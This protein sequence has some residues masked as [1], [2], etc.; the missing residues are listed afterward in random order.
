MQP[1][2]AAP[3]QPQP[4]AVPSAVPVAQPIQPQN[5]VAPPVATSPKGSRT[6]GKL[7][8]HEPI[9]KIATIVLTLGIIGTSIGLSF[10]IVTVR[11]AAYNKLP[12]IQAKNAQQ[13][14]GADVI[15]RP[16]DTLDLSQKVSTYLSI[17]KQTISAKLH[18][19]VN[20]SNG[21]S[22]IITGVQK[23]W[24]SPDKYS[25]PPTAGN[26]YVKL[27]MSVGNRGDVAQS[28]DYSGLTITT[29]GQ[30]QDKILYYPFG[31]ELGSQKN[32]AD[33]FNNIDQGQQVQGAIIIQVPAGTLPALTFTQHGYGTPTDPNN[34]S[35]ISVLMKAQVAL[36]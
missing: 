8:S 4:L 19:Q 21:L 16:D 1:L 5:Q 6:L 28:L 30:V 10:H 3:V 12:W 7:H 17:K 31:A 35:D 15:D 22:F 24:K 20:F 33:D 13:A 32:L 2:P 36:Q 9:A 27:N 14:F 29:N 25:L 26:Y 11:H 18:Q 23:D 34:T